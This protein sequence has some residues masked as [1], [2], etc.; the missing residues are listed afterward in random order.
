MKKF[1]IFVCLFCILG[2][3]VSAKSDETFYVYGEDNKEIC[4]ILG[5]TEV[6]L[7]EYVEYT[8]ITY[9]AVNKQNTKQ[10]KKTE[11][12]D[13][14][15]QK[16]QN[17]LS[18]EDSEIL[19][20]SPNLT[21]MPDIKGEIVEKGGRKYLKVSAKTEDSGGEYIL[22]QYITVFGGKKEIL[23]FYTD[24]NVGTNYIDEYFNSQFE[25]TS[26]VFK[27]VAI[28]GTI[29]FSVLGLI[30]LVA[31]IKDTFIAKEG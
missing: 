8:D 15:S 16:V 12:E 25:E 10:I 1:L 22:T 30:V 6:E 23:S 28:T 14:F 27:I 20:L 13:E 5:M 29:F 18:L 4:E 26:P 21:D 11:Y 24:I 31:I 17:F 3:N 19:A 9:L 2:L 7:K